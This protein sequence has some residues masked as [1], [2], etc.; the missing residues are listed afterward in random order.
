MLLKFVQAGLRES[1]SLDVIQTV[2]ICCR[3]S[4]SESLQY[5]NLRPSWS[6]SLI[7]IVLSARLFTRTI[8]T[9]RSSFQAVNPTGC[10]TGRV[11]R[12]TLRQAYLME[13]RLVSAS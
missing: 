11:R 3:H 10:Q 5:F 8:N 1:L 7:S 12:Q 6:A 4:W 2:R 13:G 9:R